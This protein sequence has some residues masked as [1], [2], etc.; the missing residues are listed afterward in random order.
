M[1]KDTLAIIPTVAETIKND[2][3]N[4]LLLLNISKNQN[5]VIGFSHLYFVIFSIILQ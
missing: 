4:L 3:M 2:V 1:R 5:P